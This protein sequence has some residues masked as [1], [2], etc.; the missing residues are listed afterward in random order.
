MDAEFMRR[1]R[2]WCA[3]ST[4]HQS[5]VEHDHE[6]TKQYAQRQPQGYN[7]YEWLITYSTGVY[8]IP[9]TEKLHKL[10]LLKWNLSLIYCKRYLLTKFFVVFTNTWSI[11]LFFI[12]CCIQP[13]DV[14]V[15]RTGTDQLSAKATV[16][17]PKLRMK[18][19]SVRFRF[20]PIWFRPTLPSDDCGF[21][22]FDLCRDWSL[23]AGGSLM[24]RSHTGA[25]F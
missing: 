23:V 3:R 12:F 15:V 21:G 1:R 22:R 24:A 13:Y 7:Y 14:M 25:W 11:L 6:L 19:V 17:A 20:R 8:Y 5:T 10:Q 9:E 4:F 2:L 18:W 16:S